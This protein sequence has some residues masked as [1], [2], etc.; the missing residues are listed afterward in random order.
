VNIKSCY[1]LNLDVTLFQ[2]SGLN[3]FTD[4][5]KTTATIINGINISIIYS[6]ED[7][8][9]EG[10]NTGNGLTGGVASLYTYKACS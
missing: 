2:S 7:S 1:F 4:Q 6:Y 3:L 5:A 8:S 9:G 10:G